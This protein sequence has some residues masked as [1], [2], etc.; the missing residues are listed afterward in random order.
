MF[1]FSAEQAAELS[2]ANSEAVQMA[3]SDDTE[4]C[5]QH[6]LPSDD[7]RSPQPTLN[8]PSSTLHY[9]WNGTKSS[10]YSW[11]NT[12]DKDENG[13]YTTEN[14]GSTKETKPRED[15]CFDD[16]CTDCP[17]KEKSSCSDSSSKFDASS[18]STAVAIPPDGGWGWMVCLGS[19]MCNFLADGFMFSFGIFYVELMDYFKDS[20]AKTAAIGSALL[21]TH[22]AIG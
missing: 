14:K 4:T 9:G 7:N 2:P 19:F 16:F 6:T 10:G 1:S 8:P 22:L 5:A 17:G 15:I 12:W 11:W 20:M 18:T 3:R 13:I 21:G